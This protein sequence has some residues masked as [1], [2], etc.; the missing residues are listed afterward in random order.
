MAPKL[1]TVFEL[2]DISEED[3][4]RLM[5][6]LG[7]MFT[8]SDDAVDLCKAVVDKY[9]VEAVFTSFCLRMLLEKL[10]LVVHNNDDGSVQ[11]PAR[12]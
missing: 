1:A 8:E 10:S 3:G 12:N 4:E 5:K 11:C 2:L 9:G 6:E 7:R